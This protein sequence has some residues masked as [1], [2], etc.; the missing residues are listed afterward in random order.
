MKDR[1]PSLDGLRA[2]SILAVLHSHASISPGYPSHRSE[3]IVEFSSF[4]SGDF[5]VNIF[6]V[7]SGFLITSLLMEEESTGGSISLKQFY[8]R[9]AF[10]ILPVYALYVGVVFLCKETGVV[11]DLE[12]YSF[13]PALTFTTGTWPVD[14]GWSLAHTWSLSI[15]EQFYLLW[16]IAF[17]FIRSRQSRTLLL[18]MVIVMAL[19]SR[20]LYYYFTHH[21]QYHAFILRGD[22][23][24]MG[25]LLAINKNRLN[26]FVPGRGKFRIWLLISLLISI[27]LTIMAENRILGIVTVPFTIFSQGVIASLLI[28]GY[29]INPRVESRIFRLLNLPIFI[30]IGILSY[31]LYIWQQFY[32]Q[33]GAVHT[34]KHF[35]MNVLLT[36]TSAVASYYLLEQP[37]I[38]L[39]KKISHKQHYK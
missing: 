14:T 4:F 29:C 3:A 1:Y 2:F 8:L 39:R 16:P 25:C 15:E 20:S 21:P 30:R 11:K 19:A 10:R 27:T 38:S 26:D 5:G 33:S 31:S 34:W 13:L 22:C 35:P 23:I 37:I 36:L 24:S 17:L 7:I 32:L 9:R 12:A 6:F 28:F 18:M